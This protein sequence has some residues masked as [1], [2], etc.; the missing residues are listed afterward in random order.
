MI[1][2]N[3]TDNCDNYCRKSSIGASQCKKWNEH[4]TDADCDGDTLCFKGV[5]YEEEEE[6]LDVGNSFCDKSL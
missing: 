6:E 4:L 5:I 3:V 1:C 2:E